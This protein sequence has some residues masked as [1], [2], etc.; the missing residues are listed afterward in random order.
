MRK[1]FTITPL[2]FVGVFLIVSIMLI[3]FSDFD[4][5]SV[6]TLAKESRL[7][8]LEAGFLENRLTIET[9]L[10]SIAAQ[11]AGDPAVKD[12]QDLYYNTSMAFGDIV[13]ILECQRNYFTIEYNGSYSYTDPDMEI[14]N[15]TYRIERNITCDT[16]RQVTGRKPLIDCYGPWFNC[17]GY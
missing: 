6:E 1:G 12:I 7:E 14:I 10:V 13:D 3:S 17:T 16:V 15:R 5:R 11:T 4:R 8:A 2:L 9:Y